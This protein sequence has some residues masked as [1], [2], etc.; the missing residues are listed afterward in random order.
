[1]ANPTVSIP[2]DQKIAEPSGSLT[3][4]WQRVLSEMARQINDLQARVAKLEAK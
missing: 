2:Q 3:P 4:Q 1:M